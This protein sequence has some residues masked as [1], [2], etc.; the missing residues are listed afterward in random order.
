M[1]QLSLAKVRISF[2]LSVFM[3]H[4]FL[5]RAR[6]FFA[7]TLLTLGELWSKS[8]RLALLCRRN[9]LPH[10]ARHARVYH[11]YSLCVLPPLLP[12]DYI[13]I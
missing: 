5:C 1:A 12:L 13:I 8:V 3:V 10:R 9:L 11:L 2:G 6:F 7:A 4:L